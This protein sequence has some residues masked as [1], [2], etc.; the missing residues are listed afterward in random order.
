MGS[1]EQY[2]PAPYLASLVNCMVWV[3]YGLPVVHPHST[4]VMTTNGAGTAIEVFYIV[5]FLVYS[6]KHRQRLRVLGVVAVEVIFVGVL[7]FLVLHFAETTDKRTKV[8]GIGGVCFNILMYASPLTVMK[9]VITT[10]SVEYMPFFLSLASMLNGVCWTAYGLIRFD[11]FLVLPNG[12]GLLLSLA[13]LLLYAIYY[14]NTQKILAERRARAQVGLSEV[15]TTRD[16]KT[17]ANGLN[18][19]G[20]HH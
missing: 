16:S 2:S 9:L 20:V 1:V 17:A 10:K 19:N 13:Q 6:H 7:A 5:L 4:L 18:H 12:L 8:V 3:L 11:L 15:V 14:K